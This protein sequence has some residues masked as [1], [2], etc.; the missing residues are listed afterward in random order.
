MRAYFDDGNS[1]ILSFIAY[2]AISGSRSFMLGDL[3]L[4]R[5]GKMYSKESLSCLRKIKMEVVVGIA[6][7]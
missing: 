1:I 2:R 6:G 3:N 4:N 7:G 5:I